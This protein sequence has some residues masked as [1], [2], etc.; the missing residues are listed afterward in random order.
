ME[1]SKYIE[2][3]R[4]LLKV[5]PTKRLRKSLLTLFVSFIQSKDTFLNDD[6][7]EIATDYYFLMRFLDDMEE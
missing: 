3:I 6:Y 2:L 7:I 5:A 1:D 4:D